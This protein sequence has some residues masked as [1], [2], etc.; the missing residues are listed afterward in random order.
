MTLTVRE[1]SSPWWRT[2]V[3]GAVLA[4]VVAC[5]WSGCAGTGRNS[6]NESA[7]VDP[8]GGMTNSGLGDAGSPTAG[9]F[10]DVAESLP[11]AGSGPA[12][13]Y[14][15]LTGAAYAY[16]RDVCGC[17][18]QVGDGC[19][20]ADAHE[21]S[22]LRINSPDSKRCLEQE[23]ITAFPEIVACEV[24]FWESVSACSARLLHTDC[25]R[26]MYC[27][28]SPPSPCTSLPGIVEYR[29]LKK[30]CFEVLYCDDGGEGS[31]RRCNLSAECLDGSDEANCE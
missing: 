30:R 26:G 18:G 19:A 8:S 31:G 17:F 27:A 16:A 7:P 9:N 6:T 22:G 25:F 3:Q 15:R 1:P 4:S 12:E 5:S 23:L 20:Y 13:D 24:Q 2:F 10:T 28:A 11:S 21:Y 14:E 29:Q